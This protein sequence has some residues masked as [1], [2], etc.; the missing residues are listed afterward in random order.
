[1]SEFENAIPKEEQELK[2]R[3]DAAISQV[4][5]LG[6]ED[7][8]QVA[9]GSSYCPEQADNCIEM[10]KYSCA[11]LQCDT[12]S[13]YDCASDYYHDCVSDHD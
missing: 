13:V 2:D 11:L 6:E 5:K 9:G 7:L 1:M 12:T 10:S 8:S 3:T 4:A